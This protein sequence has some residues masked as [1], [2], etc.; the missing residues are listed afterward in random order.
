M[1]SDYCCLSSVNCDDVENYCSSE[2]TRP[3]LLQSPLA[4]VLS[5]TGSIEQLVSRADNRPFIQQQCQELLQSI[6]MS[7]LSISTAAPID[8]PLQRYRE[9]L[10]LRVSSRLT[11]VKQCLT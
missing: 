6:V 4:V 7:A 8:P 10:H 2:A 5:G 1:K 11:I 3:R 9:L